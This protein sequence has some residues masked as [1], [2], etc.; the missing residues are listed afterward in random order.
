MTGMDK[1]GEAILDKVKTEAD[2]IVAE[3][4]A[5]A[6]QEI[7]QAKKQQLVRLEEEKSRI[8][9]QA[10]EEATRIEAQATVKARQELSRAKSDVIDEI[11]DRVRKQLATGSR[12][13]GSLAGLLKEAA[14][15]LG[16]AKGRVYLSPKDIGGVKKLLARDKELAARIVEVK[17]YDCSGGVI[18]EDVDGKI[19]IDDTYE[20]RLE[21]LL[22][23][24]LPE[25]GRDLFPD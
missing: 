22:P 25:I 16:T 17:E 8:L 19:R 5:K 11:I 21:M 24:L 14:A 13:E 7:E 1:I 9:R 12:D 4:E 23:R 2:G 15:P 20:T 6:S 3:A 18:V 10:G